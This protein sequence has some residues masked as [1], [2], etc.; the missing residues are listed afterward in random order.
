MTAGVGT[1]QAEIPVSGCVQGGWVQYPSSNRYMENDSFT[2]DPTIA[3]GD[4]TCSDSGK[5]LRSEHEKSLNWPTTSPVLFLKRDHLEVDSDE[6]Q[7]LGRVIREFWTAYHRA[8]KLDYDKHIGD[9]RKRH[10][11]IIKEVNKLLSVEDFSMK[12]FVDRT[13]YHIVGSGGYFRSQIALVDPE[14]K[15]IQSVASACEIEG[16]A[17]DFCTNES[18]EVQTAQ[19]FLKEQDVQV[20]VVLKRE[21]VVIPDASRPSPPEPVLPRTKIQECKKLGM[22]TIIVVPMMIGERVIGTL[23]F[24]RRDK[25]HPPEAEEALFEIL[26]SQLAVVFDRAQKL[27]LLQES[28]AV[29]RTQVSIIESGNRLLYVNDSA[30][31]KAYQGKLTNSGWQ[32]TAV[33]YEG[34][35]DRFASGPA[36]ERQRESTKKSPFKYR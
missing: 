23:H 20:W 21:K 15:A 17:V 19:N 28:L 30:L 2:E 32:K 31:S 26:A 4:L 24:E 18:L 9:I 36:R 12:N 1:N 13:A 10:L 33:K 8:M 6:Y 7:T 27:T 14:W 5:V 25:G 34:Y 29:M 3:F 22:Q 35:A 16:G 11:S